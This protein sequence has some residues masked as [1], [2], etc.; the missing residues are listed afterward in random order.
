[1]EFP[2][3]CFLLSMCF[4]AFDFFFALTPFSPSKLSFLFLGSFF[5]TQLFWWMRTGSAIPI[6]WSKHCKSE[7]TLFLHL[8]AAN[9][10]SSP[11]C[12]FL[13][14]RKDEFPMDKEICFNSSKL[15]KLDWA[16]CPQMMI[17]IIDNCCSSYLSSLSEQKYENDL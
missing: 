8:G 17:I 5:G 14:Q 3:F 16:Q 10:S 2:S 4:F 12:S 6:P 15:A 11:V 7:E 1:M 9:L 13:V